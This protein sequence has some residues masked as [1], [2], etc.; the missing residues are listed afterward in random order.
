M[1]TTGGVCIGEMP[2]MRDGYSRDTHQTGLGCAAAPKQ[3]QVMEQFRLLYLMLDNVE[4]EIDRAEGRLVDVLSPAC[5][6][7]PEKRSELP[8]I[9]PAASRIRE[10]GM[11]LETSWKRL[12]D[13]LNRVEL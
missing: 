2:A 3:T 1:V 5:P 12:Q 11:R 7:T 4:A 6:P 13:I 10:A 9:V 8:E